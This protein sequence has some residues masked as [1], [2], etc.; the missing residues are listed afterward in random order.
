MSEVKSEIR[1]A[2]GWSVAG[3]VAMIFFGAIAIAAPMIAAL[4]AGIL[5]GVAVLFGGAAQLV[6]AFETRAEPRFLLRLAVGI[7]YVLAGY[8]LLARPEIGILSLAII[9]GTFLF[10]QGLLTAILGLQAR[11]AAGWGWLLFDGAVSILLG[12]LIWA[13]WPSDAAWLIGTFFG[14]S[15]L[16]SGFSRVMWSMVARKVVS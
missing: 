10:A 11:P 12:L 8:W 2:L 5:V 9:L 16:C 1:S 15:L 3:G 13:H 6:H 7:L 14:I 4:S